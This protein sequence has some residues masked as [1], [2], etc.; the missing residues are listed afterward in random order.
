MSYITYDDYKNSGLANID[1]I[2]FKKLLPKAEIAM[3]SKTNYFYKENDLNSDNPRR[4]EAFITA[5]C[6]TIEQMDQTGIISEIDILSLQNI[7]IGST[8]L[9]FKDSLNLVQIVP[10]EALGLLGSVGL[11]YS[12]VAYTRHLTHKGGSF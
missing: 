3:D 8:S 6:L 2:T 4:K 7:S 12:G 1:E 9:G 10:S 11:R 5:L